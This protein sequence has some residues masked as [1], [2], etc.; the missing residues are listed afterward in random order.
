V[1]P[2][3]SE[4]AIAPAAKASPRGSRAASPAIRSVPPLKAAA[5]QDPSGPACGGTQSWHSPSL[6]CRPSASSAPQT[7]KLPAALRAASLVRNFSP[8]RL[9]LSL[10]RHA[11]ALMRAAAAPPP[12]LTANARSHRKPAARTPA[13]RRPPRPAPGPAG[14]DCPGSKKR[15]RAPPARP[16]AK[17][18]VRACAGR[19]GPAASPR[20]E[21]N[22]Q[23]SWRPGRRSGGRS[24]PG[25]PCAH[26][27]GHGP[28]T[29]FALPSVPRR[30][31]P[32][33][34]Q[35]LFAQ[36]RFQRSFSPSGPRKNRARK[37]SSPAAQK[38]LGES[39][40]KPRRS[41]NSL[42]QRGQ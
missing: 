17:T 29:F 28:C 14:P 33:R 4:A 7:E 5:G 9:T 32:S 37:T 10:R 31:L 18:P 13:E 11:A 24:C 21:K 19:A 30:L 25:L 41:L 39:A 3:Y 8:G 26:L 40:R 20:R 23:T 1:R 2:G 38:H 22:R 27:R 16:A 12:A 36:N 42:R 15:T 35:D 6:A 34:T